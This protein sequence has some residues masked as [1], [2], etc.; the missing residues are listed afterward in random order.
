MSK[1]KFKKV[2]SGGHHEVWCNGNNHVRLAGGG[3]GSAPV[4]QF[5]IPPVERVET[6]SCDCE[7]W[8]IG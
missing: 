3:M 5:S 7:R 2:Y 6:T 8:K 4:S 1:Q